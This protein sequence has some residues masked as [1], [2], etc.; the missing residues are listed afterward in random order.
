MSD[1][2]TRLWKYLELPQVFQS[3]AGEIDIASKQHLRICQRLASHLSK[4][5]P[6]TGK[7]FEQHEYL[8]NFVVKTAEMNQ[9]TIE[10]LEYLRGMV[11][12]IANDTK[13]LR[14]GAALTARI[15]DQGEKILQTMRERDEAENKYHELRKRSGSTNKT[16]V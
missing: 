13:S 6:K 4:Q 8:K 2:G 9:K 10:L 5:K 12:E 11:Q 16:A 14:E 7:E 1:D 15:K 3:R